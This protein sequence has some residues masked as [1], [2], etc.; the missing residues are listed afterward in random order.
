VWT[1]IKWQLQE[2]GI[3]DEHIEM[4]GICTACRTDLFYSH[5]AEKGKTGRFGGLTV[6]RST[7]R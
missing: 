7:T 6:L 5:R 2:S 3:Q 4:S 1:A